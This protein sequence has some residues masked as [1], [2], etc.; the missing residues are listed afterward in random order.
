MKLNTV[1]GLYIIVLR[2]NTNSGKNSGFHRGGGGGGGGPVARNYP[3]PTLYHN[4][5]LRIYLKECSI[6]TPTL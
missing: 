2:A 5:I 4:Y 6:I 1:Q 3:G